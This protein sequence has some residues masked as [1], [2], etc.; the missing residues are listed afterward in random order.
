[1]SERKTIQSYEWARVLGALAVVCL[2]AVVATRLVPEL[3][4]GNA[5]LFLAEDVLCVPLTRWAVPVFFMVSGALLLDPGRQMTLE[6]VGRYV[7]RMAFILLTIGFAFCVMELVASFGFYGLLTF[8]AA[9]LNLLQG[10]SWGHLWYVYALIGLYLITPI[11]SAY[12]RVA[13]QRDLAIVALVGYAL[14]CVAPTIDLVAGT[15][16]Y[17]FL[18]TGSPVV[19]YLAGYYASTYL[20]LDAKVIGAG[21]LALAANLV[22]FAFDPELASQ[23]ALPEYAFALP[24]SVLAF[25]AIR[26]LLERPMRERGLARA[27]ARDS[28]GIYLLH[29]LF[30]HVILLVP[31]LVTLPLPV[32]QLTIVVVGVAG[33]VV[34]TRLLRLLP[35]FASKL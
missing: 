29:P 28:F 26:S 4:Q 21:A 30:G 18:G 32:L 6:K 13:T 27:L 22:A 14:L 17:A 24:F 7:W 16:L 19:Y 23:L 25:V 34:L 10:L 12:V 2:H 20:E 1:M 9:F 8:Q 3:H 31:A 5:A 33:S 11:L 35:P 15:K